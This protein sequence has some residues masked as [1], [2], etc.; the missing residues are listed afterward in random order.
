MDIND[1]VSLFSEKTPV[2]VDIKNTSHGEEDFRETLLVDF[3]EK[4]IVIKLS[5]N[6]FTDEKHLAMWERIAKEYR[7]L[8]YYCPQFIRALD[9]TYP[10]VVYKDK[11]C[12]VWGEEFSKYKSAEELIKDKFSDTKL[13]EEGWYSFFEDAMIMDAKVAACH[14]DYTDLPSAYCMFEPFDPSDTSDETTEDAEKWLAIAQNLPDKYKG[15][16]ERIWNNWLEARKELE[17]IYHQL[18]TSVFQADINDTNVLLDEDGRFKGV[19][20]FNIGGREVFINYLVRQAP[21]VSTDDT[22]GSIDVDD[23]FLKRVL[24][25][26]DIVKKVYSFNDLEKKAAPLLY[27]CI[28][29]LWWHASVELEEAGADDEKILRHLDA[30][31]YEQTRDIDFSVHM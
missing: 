17:K 19:Y 29:P 1:I 9:G 12:R 18:P 30:V 3:G 2:N 16:V 24:H 14:F 28:R 21:Y 22:Y 15:Q 6:G 20:D 23:N 4:R 5:A 31:E 7:G 11:N 26:L 10:T 8:G 25:A 27:K 13:V